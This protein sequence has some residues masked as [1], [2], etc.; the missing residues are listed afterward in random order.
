MDEQNCTE[1]LV[2]PE[3]EFKKKPT[4]TR[5]QQTGTE[6]I[7]EGGVESESVS[8]EM[9]DIPSKSIFTE[10]DTTKKIYR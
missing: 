10:E 7:R 6:S 8:N 3:T 2:G 9:M 1:R 5:E 4:S